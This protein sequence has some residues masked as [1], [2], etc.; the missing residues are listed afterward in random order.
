MSPGAMTD[1]PSF[2]KR[3]ELLAKIDDRD[4]FDFKVVYEEYYD[5]IYKFSFPV[6]SIRIFSFTLLKLKQYLTIQF[7][8]NFKIQAYS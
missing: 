2:D 8:H 3:Q 1:G 6:T 4:P 5:I 7:R